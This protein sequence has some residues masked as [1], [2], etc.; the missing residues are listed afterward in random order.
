MNRLEREVLEEIETD[1]EFNEDKAVA[2]VALVREA[3][4]QEIEDAKPSEP[5]TPTITL[6]D[7]SYPATMA[8]PAT[9]YTTNNTSG[10]TLT[11]NAITQTVQSLRQPP[12]PPTLNVANMPQVIISVDHLRR[13]AEITC[14]CGDRNIV[15]LELWQGNEGVRQ[16]V[17]RYINM[18]LRLKHYIVGDPFKLP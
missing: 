6:Q 1:Y 13:F 11:V 12:K 4:L 16:E 10:T 2:I 15:P 3:V 7:Y 17:E 9:Y 14:E 8:N 5:Q 18:H